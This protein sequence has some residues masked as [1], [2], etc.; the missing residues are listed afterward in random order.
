VDVRDDGLGGACIDCD[1]DSSGL[2]G[3]VDRVEALH[4]RI[5]LTSPSGGGTRLVATFPLA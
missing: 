4:G 2:G 3:L 1:G 5:E